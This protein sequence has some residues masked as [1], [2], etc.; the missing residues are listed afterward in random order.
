[1]SSSKKGASFKEITILFIRRIRRIFHNNKKSAK[2]LGYNKLI[3]DEEQRF[4]IYNLCLFNN[5]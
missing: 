3:T 4:Y 1:M 5:K 2:K